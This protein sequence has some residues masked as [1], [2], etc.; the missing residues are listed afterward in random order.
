MSISNVHSGALA[1]FCC[2]AGC[3]QHVQPSCL[4]D[5]TRALLAR[6]LGS[7]H[8]G[9]QKDSSGGA[10][11]VVIPDGSVPTTAASTTKENTMQTGPKGGSTRWSRKRERRRRQLPK[12]KNSTRTCRERGKPWKR[13]RNSKTPSEEMRTA[14]EAV[15]CARKRICPTLALAT[16]MET[17]LPIC[18][19]I[20]SAGGESIEH[21]GP[22]NADRHPDD[23][24]RGD[25]ASR[26]KV[27]S[28]RTSTGASV[29][30]GSNGNTGN[31]SG[32]RRMKEQKEA[33]T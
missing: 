6:Y 3:S 30:C 27:R 10:R 12:V 16:N 23:G 5:A 20:R 21:R 18:D 1:P 31:G 7:K 8:D 13:R 2:A 29:E 17:L 4:A 33:K 11:H 9:T 22:A 15:E 26:G 28:Q 24:T 25:N 19:I 32:E 14:S